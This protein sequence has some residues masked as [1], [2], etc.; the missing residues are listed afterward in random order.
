M[1]NKPLDPVIEKFIAALDQSAGG[2]HGTILE[3]KI[4]GV[5][6]RWLNKEYLE[7]VRAVQADLPD[8]KRKEF[9]LA[10]RNGYCRDC[11]RKLEDGET[12]YCERC[13]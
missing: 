9:W 7:I 10:L 11:A 3:I 8:E 13:E 5:L 2:I 6:V 4:K 12:R 1:S